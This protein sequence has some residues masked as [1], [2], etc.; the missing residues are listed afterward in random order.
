[1]IVYWS[2]SGEIYEEYKQK[3]L[4]ISPFYRFLFLIV[5]KKT[6]EFC[7]NFQSIMSELE[8]S[9]DTRYKC[10]EGSEDYS[11]NLL[12][13]ML[14]AALK[15]NQRRIIDFILNYDNF[16]TIEFEFSENI[17]PEEIHYYTALKLLKQKHEIGRN[18]I[19]KEWLTNEVL[20][21]FFDSQITFYNQDFIEICCNCML[22]T[23]SQK[24]IVK[25]EKDVTDKLVM[26]DDTNSLEYLTGQENLK[27][28][29][30][31]PVIETYINLKTL[32]YQRIFTWNF[33]GFVLLFIIPFTLLIMQNHMGTLQSINSDNSTSECFGNFSI[34]CYAICDEIIRHVHI[35][36]LIYIFIREGFQLL[37]SNT[38]KAYFFRI[39]NIF[40]ITLIFL[41]LTLSI[42]TLSDSV[43]LKGGVTTSLEVAFI[44]FTTISATS[45]LPFAHV[46]INMQILKKVALTFLRI[47]YTFAIILIAFSF[48][49][50]IM[51]EHDNKMM[52]E[53]NGT[54]DERNVLKNFNLP[55]RS[56]IKIITM[57]GGGFKF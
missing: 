25:S 33:W 13:V 31:H 23:H 41:S 18:K 51:F 17:I 3:L 8:E 39:S 6:D 26:W 4:Q 34:N 1:M 49:F 52:A 42:S 12:F 29:I 54:E 24:M 47:F 9:Y 16:E 50:C 19:P 57:V 48:S 15:T 2:P 21:E 5:E 14:L 11:S 53:S 28:L 30:L 46:P 40:D 36:G 55:H 38:W 27:R 45:I 7:E 32:K 10:T 22:H 20:E 56:L 37:I 44:L 35:I 43:G